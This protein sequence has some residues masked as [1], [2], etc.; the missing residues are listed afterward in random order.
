MPGDTPP[1]PPSP[2]QPGRLERTSLGEQLLRAP[3]G[4]AVA[5]IGCTTGAQPCALTLVEGLALFAAGNDRPRRLGDA[6][7][8]AVARYWR[9]ERLAELTPTDDWYPPS[10]FFQGMKF[11]LLGDPSL[12][13]P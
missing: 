7:N 6:W 4:G 12:P 3:R 2:L 8:F 9:E 13:L 5:Y 10:I 1:A 11:I